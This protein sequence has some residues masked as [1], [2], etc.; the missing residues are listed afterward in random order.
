MPGALFILSRFALRV[1]N[2]IF[3]TYDTRIYHSFTSSL[4]VREVSGWEAPYDHVQ[5]VRSSLMGLGLG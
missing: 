5:R 2:V 4:I 3:R 1:D